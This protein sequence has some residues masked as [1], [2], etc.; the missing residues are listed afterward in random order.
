MK[1][2]SAF[3]RAQSAL[4]FVVVF[5]VWTLSAQAVSSPSSLKVQIYEMRLSKNSDCSAALSVF[6]TASPTSVD[7]FGSPDLGSGVISTGTYHCVMFHISD[8]V[9]FVP[10]NNIEPMCSSTT[11]YHYDIFQSP[12]V[13]VSP[14]GTLINA[15]G[16]PTT[17]PEDSP[18]IYLSDAPTAAAT[19]GCFQPTKSGAEGPC[20]MA[21]LTIL[22]DQPHTLVMNANGQLGDWGQGTCILNLTRDNPVAI[23]FR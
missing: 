14:E 20:P 3:K 15:T 21:P 18:W 23:S 8:I 9:S 11:T 10:A 5:L 6:N 1:K 2:N 12:A 19:N 16:T 17:F 22:S 13:S 4:A 7:L